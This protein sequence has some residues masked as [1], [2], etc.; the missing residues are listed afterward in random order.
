MPPPQK[1]KPTLEI[2][3]NK[4]MA[5]CAFAYSGPIYI[6]LSTL[7]K[8]KYGF[9]IAFQILWIHSDCRQSHI[10]VWTQFVHKTCSSHDEPNDM[11][12]DEVNQLYT[13]H[14]VSW[15]FLDDWWCILGKFM[16]I[17]IHPRT[18][19]CSHMMFLNKFSPWCILCSSHCLYP[20]WHSLQTHGIWYII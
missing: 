12:D 2:K 10:W 1:L 16:I 13:E 3:K 18:S 6:L 8:N 19:N 4:K 5:Q 15:G 11:I 9:P 7:K 17:A 20:I 14:I